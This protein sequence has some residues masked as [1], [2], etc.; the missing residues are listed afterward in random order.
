MQHD[1]EDTHIR[2]E[3]FASDTNVLGES[4]AEHHYLLV[5]RREAEDLLHIP[6]HIWRYQ[7]GSKRGKK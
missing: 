5:V 7:R 1:E 2:H 6:A 4:G 3:F